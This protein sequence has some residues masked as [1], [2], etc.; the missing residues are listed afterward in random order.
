MKIQDFEKIRSK[1]NQIISNEEIAKLIKNNDSLKAVIEEYNTVMMELEMQTIELNKTQITLESEKQKYKDLFYNSPVA[2]VV[3]DV[4]GNI[5]DINTTA[6][7]LLN[8][9]YIANAN[10]FLTNLVTSD[11]PKFF[12]FLQEVL[13]AN[14][15]IKQEFTFQDKNA[16]K[17]LR[18]EFVGVK[19]I[20][21]INYK[22]KIRIVI[23]DIT[24]RYE[25]QL[26]TEEIYQQ[27]TSML[28]SGNVAWWRMDVKSKTV[29]YHPRKAEILGYT[30][31]E[32]GKDVY[33][34]L[35]LVHP[36]DL[37]DAKKAMR[38]HLEGRTKYY[39]IVYRTKTKDG[40]YKWI[41]DRGQIAK[42]DE[43][44]NPELVIGI[45][46][47]ITEIKKVENLLLEER[48][49]LML[50]NDAKSKLVSI[51]SHD[52]RSP[53]ATILNYLELLNERF[54]I[55]D[56]AKKKEII[57]IVYQTS[58]SSLDL[59]ENILEWARSD[60]NKIQVNK[61]QVEI[62]G[63]IRQQLDV[64]ENSAKLKNIKFELVGEKNLM[65]NTDLN[66]FST[67][68]R[69]LIS[70]AVK[71]SHK[72]SVIEINYNKSDSMVIFSIKDSG[73]GMSQEQ[74]NNLFSISHSFSRRGTAGERG[75]GFGLKI[76]KE[77][78]NKLG[79]KIWV[80]SQVN[81]GT[82]F[83]FSLPLD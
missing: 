5:I 62:N 59:L 16:N 43:E 74:I 14:Q 20:D 71:F 32:F 46:T 73:I 18:L 15:P 67:I 75:T 72:D 29:D 79:G 76:V 42:Y 33:K 13:E 12:R 65:I 61:V 40:E 55:F 10:P 49:K 31:E 52:L 48:N 36:E 4:N 45:F 54:E 70:N 80:E 81:V 30:P 78:L 77:Y 82:T 51:L 53:F 66:L 3:V 38:D 56:D 7:T 17:N 58:K 57:N 60:S 21:P 2:F 34:I 35:E 11:L 26:K 9:N 69:N 27:L 8:S 6:K 19:F 68:I 23:H 25:L 63:F 83:Y 39:E 47:D 1:I 28:M 50:A 24:Q 22:E 64:F 44:G 37:E 41:M